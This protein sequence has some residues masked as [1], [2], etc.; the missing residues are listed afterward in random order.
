MAAPN[1]GKLSSMHFY[2]WK[3]GLKT[4]M[5]YLRT[6]PAV[7]ATKFTVAPSDVKAAAAAQAKTAAAAAAAV[8]EEQAAVALSCSIDNPEDCMSCGS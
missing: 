2:G 4:G 1:I 6:R 3:A 7:D 8:K 5:Y